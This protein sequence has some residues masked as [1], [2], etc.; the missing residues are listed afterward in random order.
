MDEVSDEAIEVATLGVSVELVLS[1]VDKC[2]VLPSSL[3]NGVGLIEVVGCIDV[4]EVD[5][6]VDDG[7]VEVDSTG[8]MI[9]EV[10][11]A[12]VDVECD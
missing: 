9:S 2:V 11:D 8:I 10:G 12:S 4:V 6:I 1:T 3:R 7:S 5:C